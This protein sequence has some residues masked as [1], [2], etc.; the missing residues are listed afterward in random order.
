MP[1]PSRRGQVH[2]AHSPDDLSLGKKPSVTPIQWKKKLEA[3]P[4]HFPSVYFINFGQSG[5][6]VLVWNDFVLR[7]HSTGLLRNLLNIR[8]FKILIEWLNM[9][10]LRGGSFASKVLD[11]QYRAMDLAFWIFSL[12]V[13]WWLPCG[14]RRNNAG[15]K[16]EEKRA[17]IKGK[18]LDLPFT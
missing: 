6:G 3:I 5:D 1:H 18:L 14:E 15:G 10:D 12:R 16:R 2:R 9:E 7:G 4:A 13:C 8:A 11:L 17:L